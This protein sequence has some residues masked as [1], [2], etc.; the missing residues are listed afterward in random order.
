MDP[1]YKHSLGCADLGSCK[2]ET[3]LYVRVLLSFCLM[4]ASLLLCYRSFTS[5]DRRLWNSRRGAELKAPGNFAVPCRGRPSASIGGKMSSLP[6]LRRIHFFSSFFACSEKGTSRTVLYCCV[7]A[8]FLR[9][10][11][12]L[13]LLTT[14]KFWTNI[15]SVT[16]SGRVMPSGSRGLVLTAA[17]PLS[18]MFDCVRVY[19]FVMGEGNPRLRL[20]QCCLAGRWCCDHRSKGECRFAPSVCKSGNPEH[21]PHVTT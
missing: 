19:R 18:C 15:S 14:W 3:N 20:W 12:F 9:F 1:N 2:N 16:P 10:R 21:L 5:P 6:S 4:V 7:L 8:L 17:V 11:F 13:A